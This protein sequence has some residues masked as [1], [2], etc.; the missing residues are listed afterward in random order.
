[1]CQNIKRSRTNKPKEE[2]EEN[3]Q[4]FQM[5]TLDGV[6]PSHVMNLDETNLS[7]DPELKNVIT[8]RGTKHP[9]QAMNSSKLATLLMYA[10]LADG[11]VLPPY[12]VYKA[13]NMQ[14]TWT[15]GG[16]QKE[17]VTT[18]ANLD[19]LTRNVSVTGL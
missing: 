11:K 6:A 2:F 16:A 7:D 4:N 10:A 12:V 9:E 13:V 19:G 15:N 5:E 3:F 14:G 1:M 8:K 18:A 17:P